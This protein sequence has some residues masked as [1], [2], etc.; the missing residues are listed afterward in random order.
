MKVGALVIFL[1]LG[2]VGC[3]PDY[4]SQDESDVLFR[5]SDINNTASFDSNLNSLTEDVVAVTVAVRAKNPNFDNVPQV[6]LAVFVEQYE[7]RYFRTDGRSTEGV[8][9][10][11]RFTGG[12]RTAVDAQVSGGTALI[13]PIVRIQAKEEPPLRNLRAPGA[14]NVGAGGI[15]MTVIAEITVY[16]RQTNGRPVRDTGRLTINFAAPVQAR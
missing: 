15:V 16:G 3:V 14:V 12:L 8:D 4:V 11:Y 13:I 1:A 5:I 10:P 9:V 2:L 7:V 6:P